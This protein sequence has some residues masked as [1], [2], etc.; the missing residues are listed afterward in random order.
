MME[1][2][3]FVSVDRAGRVRLGEWI[4]F[5]PLARTPLD[6]AKIRRIGERFYEMGGWTPEISKEVGWDRP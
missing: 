6:A 2:P 5:L 1:Y 4:R 3:D